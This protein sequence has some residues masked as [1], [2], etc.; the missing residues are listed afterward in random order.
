MSG[1]FL[2][3][4]VRNNTLSPYKS[5]YFEGYAI[6]GLPVMQPFLSLVYLWIDVLL[7]VF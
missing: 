7:D 2:A 6:F 3:C 1:T 4:R 5:L